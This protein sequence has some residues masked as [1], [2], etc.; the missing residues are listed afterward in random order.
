MEIPSQYKATLELNLLGA[1]TGYSPGTI[2]LPPPGGSNL[3]T[4]REYSANER[5]SPSYDNRVCPVCLSNPKD[6]A[7]GC[8]HQTC[9]NCGIDLLLCPICRDL[10]D[11]KIRLYH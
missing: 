3:Q 4:I 8:G 6:M 2:P 9:C 1:R 5:T 7:F 11:T 10:I